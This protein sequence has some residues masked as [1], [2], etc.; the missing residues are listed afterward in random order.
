MSKITGGITTIITS[1]ET[2][3][4]MQRSDKQ[5]FRYVKSLAEQSK[6]RL[7]ALMLEKRTRYYNTGLTKAAK[8]ALNADIAI[9][10][11][12]MKEIDDNVTKEGVDLK[13]LRGNGV[14]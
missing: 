6:G 11:A 1:M 2:L 13:N 4:N 12:R 5:R 10:A 14:N 7:R 3:E 8:D 9:L